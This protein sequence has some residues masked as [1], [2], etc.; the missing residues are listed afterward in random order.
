MVDR[1]Q[2]RSKLRRANLDAA[3]QFC[4]MILHQNGFEF[5]RIAMIYNR[6]PQTIQQAVFK[7]EHPREHDTRRRAWRMAVRFYTANVGLT[8]KS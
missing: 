6:S 7:A 1:M 5:D 8:V 3:R 2:V 4:W